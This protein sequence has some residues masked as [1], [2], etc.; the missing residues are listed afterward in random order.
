MPISREDKI[1]KI[2]DFFKSVNGK[3]IPPSYQ[4][5]SLIDSS[6]DALLN[7]QD[8]DCVLPIMLNNVL[9]YFSTE[10]N[11]KVFTFL[12]DLLQISDIDDKYFGVSECIE[13]PSCDNLDI[14]ESTDGPESGYFSDNKHNRHSKNNTEYTKQ[15]RSIP[16]SFWQNK[17]EIEYE[18]DC[19][20]PI[21]FSNAK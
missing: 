15:T 12:D 21:A 8:D 20:E 16:A 5:E 7:I 3:N 6:H 13:T 17:V 14:E 4:I 18:V 1:T 10:D 19:S 11:H 9:L 2:D